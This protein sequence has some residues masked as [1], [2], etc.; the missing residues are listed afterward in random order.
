M[1][2]IK[3]KNTELEESVSNC[4]EIIKKMTESNTNL[5][6][7]IK[8]LNELFE[9]QS[10]NIESIQNENKQLLKSHTLDIEQVSLLDQKIK[11]QNEDII[12]LVNKNDN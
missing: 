5:E 8:E 10:N 4:N 1:N 6:L 11:D 2:Q 3:L 9:N 7:K 12:N